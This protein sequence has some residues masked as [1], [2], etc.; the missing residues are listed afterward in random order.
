[1]DVRLL[2]PQNWS[3]EP[4]SNGPFISCEPK[5]DNPPACYLSVEIRKAA[6][7]QNAIT[8]ADRQKWREWASSR[9]SYP[10]RSTRDVKISRYPAFETV[11]KMDEATVYRVF[12]LMDS[13]ARVIDMTFYASWGGKDY[14]ERYKPAM[15]AVLSTL[16]PAGR[17][18]KPA[19]RK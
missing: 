11:A 3:W 13:P 18:G 6:P 9:G 1:M 17:S 5:R 4:K 15:D 7:N 12:V 10:I 8:D 19:A 2:I 16:A 14:Y